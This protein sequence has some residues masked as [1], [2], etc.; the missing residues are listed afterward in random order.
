M[1][2]WTCCLQ[3]H[4]MQCTAQPGV[5]CRPWQPRITDDEVIAAEPEAEQ[6]GFS[7]IAAAG[8][9]TVCVNVEDHHHH[10]THSSH[11]ISAIGSA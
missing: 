10:I 8:N 2:H 11:S 4:L 3:T 1:M 6:H 9:S 7:A 5:R